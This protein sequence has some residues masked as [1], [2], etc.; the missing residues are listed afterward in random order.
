MRVIRAPEVCVEQHVGGRE[1]PVDLVHRVQELHRARHFVH[2]A[3]DEAEVEGL[4][5]SGDGGPQ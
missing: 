2:H 4:A 3:Q 1:V 5:G